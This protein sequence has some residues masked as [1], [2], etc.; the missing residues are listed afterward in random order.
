MVKVLVQ[1]CGCPQS[2]VTVQVT[3]LL[4]P[5]ND[6]KVGFCGVLVTTGLVPPVKLNDCNQLL[7]ARFIAASERQ[8]ET[9]VAFG[10][11]SITGLEAG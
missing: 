3:S 6:G 2:S 10:Q 9:D 7:K 5:H 8:A 4:P 11:F 1:D